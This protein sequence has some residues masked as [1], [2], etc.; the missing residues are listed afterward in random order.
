ME[1]T[2][3]PPTPHQLTG[4]TWGNYAGYK[5][6]HFHKDFMSTATSEHPPINSHVVTVSGRAI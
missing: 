5:Q 4:A 6:S 2:T 1:D 3:F